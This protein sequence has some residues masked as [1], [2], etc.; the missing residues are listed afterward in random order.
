MNLERI[1]KDFIVRRVI[2]P[3]QTSG[4]CYAHILILRHPYFLLS[5]AP[6]SINTPKFLQ[7]LVASA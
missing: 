7:C 2:L 1:V 6:K 5:S 4:K 3:V